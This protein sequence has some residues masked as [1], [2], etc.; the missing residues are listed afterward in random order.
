MGEHAV[1]SSLSLVSPAE[2]KAH[3]KILGELNVGFEKAHLDARLL[4]S[5]QE[6][7]NLATKVIAAEFIENKARRNNQWFIESANDAGLE[8]DDNVLDEGL[9]GGNK[10]EQQQLHEARR[11]KGQAFV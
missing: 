3:S 9:A 5:A 6:R 1:G 2:E 11:A 7:A 4:S 10:K 8:V